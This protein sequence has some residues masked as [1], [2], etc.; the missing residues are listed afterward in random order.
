MN[1]NV[2]KIEWHDKT[3]IVRYT[4]PIHV[5]DRKMKKT[6]KPRKKYGDMTSEEKKR[7]DERRVKY[8]KQKINYLIDICR[9]NKLHLFVTL[10][11]AEEITSYNE[12]KKL[13]DKFLKRLKYKW[14]KDI[15]YVATHELQRNRG[16]VWHFHM[17]LSL[18]WISFEEL[19]SCW[20]YG[21]VYVTKIQEKHLGY[22]FK[23]I[24]KD[25]MEKVETSERDN[26]RKI[27]C[28]RNLE[29]PKIMK[30]M[31]EESAE[32]IIFDNQ[33]SV[34]ESCSYPIKN[35]L[36]MQINQAEYIKIKKEKG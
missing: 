35:Y 18:D 7:S 10:T 5:Q 26:S 25:I 1:Y 32:D 13:W 23:Y 17:L 15:K 3:E 31:I 19:S 33:E 20:G 36:G 16:N 34:L 8:Y 14:G 12:A 4:L 24:V 2:K 22:I 28:S 30:A 11:F 21:F 9:L 29:K 6:P 27:Y